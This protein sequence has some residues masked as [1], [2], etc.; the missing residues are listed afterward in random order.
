[1]ACFVAEIGTACSEEPKEAHSSGSPISGIVVMV[2]N[3]VEEIW[4]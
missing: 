2:C 4:R 1:M 3:S